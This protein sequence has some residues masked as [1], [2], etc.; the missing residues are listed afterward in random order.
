MV[1]IASRSK[2]IN[3]VCTVPLAPQPGPESVTIIHSYYATLKSES[4]IKVP[5]FQ[6]AHH[7][8]SRRKANCTGRIYRDPS[9]VQVAAGS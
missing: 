9:A 3:K 8:D 6:K 5:P 7:L 2:L 1:Y 4:K